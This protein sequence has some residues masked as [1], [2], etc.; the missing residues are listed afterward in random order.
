ML[1]VLIGIGCL[2]GSV[3]SYINKYVVV[4]C[5]VCAVGVM[6]YVVMNEFIL[7]YSWKENI[8]MVIILNMIGIIIVLLFLE[9]LE[10]W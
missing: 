1:G 4:G 2:V 3:I 8:K 7:E 5:F 9:W 10:L 6:L